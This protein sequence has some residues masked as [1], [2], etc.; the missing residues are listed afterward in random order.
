MG[1]S[2]LWALVTERH[3]KEYSFEDYERYK[4]SSS[5]KRTYS[6]MTTILGVVTPGVTNRKNG[7]KFS[8]RFGKIFNGKA[9][10]PMMM[11]RRNI[12]APC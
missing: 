9:S 10:C 3:P 7:L 12:I 5:T 4:K 8:D 2:G 11:R 1:T 6:I